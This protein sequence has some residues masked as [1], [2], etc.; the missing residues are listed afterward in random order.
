MQIVSNT[1]VNGI[2]RPSRE[3]PNCI[4]KTFNGTS[5]T[6]YE[7]GDVVPEIDYGTPDL[8]EYKTEAELKGLLKDPSTL[9]E[10]QKYY[11]LVTG[12]SAEEIQFASKDVDGKIEASKEAEVVIDAEPIEPAP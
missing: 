10:F 9:V 5:W 2:N 6:F 3:V 12:V 11:G 7:R 1:V 8:S 4:A